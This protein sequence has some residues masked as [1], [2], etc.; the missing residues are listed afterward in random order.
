MSLCSFAKVTIDIG[1][2]FLDDITEYQVNNVRHSSSSR[3]SGK[4]T[5]TLQKQFV[6]EINEI[7]II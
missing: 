2:E 4:L 3:L 5:F 7:L 1:F 6:G